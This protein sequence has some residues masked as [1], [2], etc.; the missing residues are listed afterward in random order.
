M[1]PGKYLQNGI[2]AD[3]SQRTV[4]LQSFRT[5]DVPAWIQV[6]MQSVRSWAEQSQFGYKFLGDDLLRLVPNWFSN[7]AASHITVV[8]DLA[9]LLWAKACLDQETE[10]VI[11]IDADV[12]LFDPSQL[13][14]DANL[15]FAY[16]DEIWCS[17]DSQHKIRMSRKVN[18]SVCLFRNN[19]A[20]LRHLNRY[21]DDCLTIVR[22]QVS[23]HDHTLIGTRYLTEKDSQKR[24][25]TLQGF[26]LLSPLI[27]HAV[28]SRDRDVLAAF[29]K[30]HEAP[31]RAANLCNWFRAG[32]NNQ[33]ALSDTVYAECVNSLVQ[34]NGQCL[35]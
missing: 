24:L 27:L 12:L 2:E 35:R 28:I 1:G 29:A 13:T 19:S 30:E 4:I 8:T 20:G 25:P 6:C 31:L 9:R 14:I 7:R 21:I 16:A 34:T 18:N 22:S 5:V 17:E 10:R 33:E 23:I 15:S 26:G 11:W 3:S 32:S